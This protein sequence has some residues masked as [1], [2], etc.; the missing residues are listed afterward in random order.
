VNWYYYIRKIPKNQ[1]GQAE[2]EPPGLARK[3]ST[4]QECGA[5]LRRPPAAGNE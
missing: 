3:V 1:E 4:T 5:L 2:M